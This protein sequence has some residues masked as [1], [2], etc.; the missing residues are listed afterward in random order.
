MLQFYPQAQKT[1]P[2]S[3]LA[4]LTPQIQ[5]ILF[6]HGEVALAE[7]GR[8]KVEKRPA[9]LQRISGT[10]LPKRGELIFEA[11]KNLSYS[12]ALLAELSKAWNT[13]TEAAEQRLT[14]QVQAL[15]T[16]VAQKQRVVLPGMGWLSQKEEALVFEASTNNFL[17]E[18]FGLAAVDAYPVLS[19]TTTNK[20]APPPPAAAG[21]SKRLWLLGLVAILLLIPVIWFIWTTPSELDDS[22]AEE[23]PTEPTPAYQSGGL[24][25]PTQSAY[26]KPQR[27]NKPPVTTPPDDTEAPAEEQTKVEDPAEIPALE[28]STPPAAPAQGPAEE[29]ASAEDEHNSTAAADNAI[30]LAEADFFII[31]GSFADNTNANDYL[32]KVKSAGYTG[33]LE[34]TAGSIRVGI[35]VKGK[36]EAAKQ[37]LEKVKAQLNSEAWLQTRR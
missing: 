3:Q 15:Q 14:E 17:L 27:E 37:L 29:T 21:S 16:A 30:S 18:T 7:L 26:I 8:W 6:L 1:H 34:E 20:V 25:T 12:P 32:Q 5:Q 33:V 22:S 9:E 13:D 36:A 35:P 19:K 28:E 24:E 31:L 23:A 11:N 4:D 10:V 2:M